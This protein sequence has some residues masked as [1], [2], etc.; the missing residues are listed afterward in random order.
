MKNKN[1]LKEQ[2]KRFLKKW[3]ERKRLAYNYFIKKGE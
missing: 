3:Q 1:K 2:R